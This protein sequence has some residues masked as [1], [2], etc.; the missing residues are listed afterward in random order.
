MR[1]EKT[2]VDHNRVP[3]PGAERVLRMA[4]LIAITR[5]HRLSR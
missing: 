1:I 2:D 3:S 4:F 5:G